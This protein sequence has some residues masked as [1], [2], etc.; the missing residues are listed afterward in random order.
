MKWKKVVCFLLVLPALRFRSSFA[1]ELEDLIEPRFAF[2]NNS[3][4]LKAT[5][6]LLFLK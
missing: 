4:E 2:K 1:A 6:L 3:K 5:I